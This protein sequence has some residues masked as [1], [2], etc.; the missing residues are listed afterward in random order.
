M[1]D[2]VYRPGDE[3]KFKVNQDAPELP[4]PSVDAGDDDPGPCPITILGSDSGFY[5]FLTPRGEK[6]VYAAREL[7]R[8]T[9]T[10]LFDQAIHWLWKK[11]PTRDNKGNITGWATNA[12]IEFLIRES[13]RL[14]KFN[15]P[16]WERGPGTWLAEGDRDTPDHLV[17]HAGH[18]LFLN[19]PA[20]QGGGWRSVG[21]YRGHIYPLFEPEP[22][23]A[24]HPATNEEIA[25]LLK[26]LATWNWAHPEVGPI[27]LLG[28][29]GAA[30][31]CGALDWRPSLW[32]TGDASTGK[33]TLQNFIRRILGETLLQ[34]AE[35][36]EASIRHL[37]KGASRPVEIDEFEAEAVD[38]RRQQIVTL[39]RIASTRGGSKI[40]RGS[41]S[42]QAVMYN[43]DAVF[44]LSSIL[45]PPLSTA[46]NQR[47]TM[48]ELEALNASPAETAN[49][50]AQVRMFDGLGRRILRRLLE[51]WDDVQTSMEVI[52]AALDR[53]HHKTR[54]ADQLKILLACADVLMNDHLIDGDSAEELT[55]HFDPRS[56]ESDSKESDS[57][58]CM[59]YLLTAPSQDWAGGNRPPMVALIR[60]AI[61][62]P[63]DK[64]LHDK[65][66]AHGVRIGHFKVDKEGLSVRLCMVIAAGTHQGI[67][68]IFKGTHWQTYAS[69]PA[70]W[71]RT[72]R[73]YPGAV[74]DATRTER[75]QG[76]SHKAVIIPI[77]CLDFDFVA[78]SAEQDP[79]SDTTI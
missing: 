49:V 13:S 51:R 78:Q 61:S 14:P 44:L 27:L 68:E 76:I 55:R 43:I 22:G 5:S 17:V 32:L 74:C 6:R 60:E 70:P 33:S 29:L 72:L 24:D 16:K 31:V 47:I 4:P 19:L 23:P 9:I 67:A 40:S 71:A 75:F 35:P 11:W 1:E 79:P 73:R 65:L 21:R 3:H 66:E 25:Q 59:M 46:N 8:T 12:A 7:S 62:K 2:R 58:Q 37:L 57:L 64:T 20:E 63:N 42:G 53:L 45:P 15:M 52:A 36:T 56:V 48:L 26:L 39:L 50:K 54:A 34:V 10:D 30:T 28:W 69:R 18:A 38:Y 41:S 77:E